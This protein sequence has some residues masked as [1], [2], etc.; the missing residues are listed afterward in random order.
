MSRRILQRFPEILQ[1]IPL[2]PYTKRYSPP[3]DE[4]EVDCCVLPQRATT[5]FPAISGPSIFIVTSGQGKMQTESSNNEELKE[6]SVFFVPIDTQITIAC[7]SDLQ[8]YRA[9]VNSKFL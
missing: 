3:F 8:L 6:G 5:V 7:I 9:G 4:F 1:G 2:D